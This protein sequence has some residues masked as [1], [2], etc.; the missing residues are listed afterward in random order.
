MTSR[1]GLI[2]LV[3]VVAVAL[4]GIALRLFDGSPSASSKEAAPNLVD[5]SHWAVVL[6]AGDFR[7]HSGAPSKVFDN[8]RHDL[9]QA[10]AR[11]GFSKANMAQFSVDYDDGTQHTGVP[12]IAAAM[13][14]VASR[15]TDARLIYF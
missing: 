14:A 5:F 15:A 1:K 4:G 11:I 13:Q 8:G 12:E 7:A 9:A 6:V 10:F 2:A 3:V